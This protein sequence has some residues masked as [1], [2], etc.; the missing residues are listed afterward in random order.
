M[1]SF[2]EFCV[3]VFD[4]KQAAHVFLDCLTDPEVIGNCFPFPICHDNRADYTINV[5]RRLRSEA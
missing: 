3:C 1:F 5:A 2:P 4:L